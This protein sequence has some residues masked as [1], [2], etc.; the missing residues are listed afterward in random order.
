MEQGLSFK[1][2][3]VPQLRLIGLR[4]TRKSLKSKP[5]KHGGTEEEEERRE[6]L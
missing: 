2:F 4:I 1:Y 3:A 5:L 6:E